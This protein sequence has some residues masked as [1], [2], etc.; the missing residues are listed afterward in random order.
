MDIDDGG[1]LAVKTSSS[2]PVTPVGRGTTLLAS[3][4]KNVDYIDCERRTPSP[5]GRV[6]RLIRKNL[7]EEDADDD[8]FAAPKKGQRIF[9]G[10][11]FDHSKPNITTYVQYV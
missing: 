2:R 5:K 6:P 7:S 10:Q 8:P 4:R 11:G 3:R 1:L 9:Q